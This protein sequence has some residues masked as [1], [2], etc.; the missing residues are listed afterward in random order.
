MRKI[1]EQIGWRVA[2][3]H[4]MKMVHRDIKPQNILYDEAQD[5]YLLCDFGMTYALKDKLFSES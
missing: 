1:R 4:S 3:L 2:L 5:K